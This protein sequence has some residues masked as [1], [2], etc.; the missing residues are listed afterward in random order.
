MRQRCPRA[1]K[2][3]PLTVHAAQ[4]VFR[5]VADVTLRKGAIVQ[6]GLWKLTRE[7]EETL[8]IHEG[9]KSR[10][11]VK[12]YLPV[13]HEGV[14]QDCMFYQMATHRGI[15]PPSEV[16]LD[17]IAEGYRDFGLDLSYLDVALQE[18]W[19][20]KSITDR[21]RERHIKKGR[22]KLARA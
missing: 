7:C 16:Y 19:S 3:R 5:G 8:D 2:I 12:R 21:L 18:A 15:M 10:L 22:P 4:L 6:G 20:R 13:K 11:Y 14:V 17:T 9:I 1:K